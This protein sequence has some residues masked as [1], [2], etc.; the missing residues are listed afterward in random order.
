MNTTITLPISAYNALLGRCLRSSREYALLRNGVV[1]I[2]D[3]EQQR[4]GIVQILCEPEE[5]QLIFTLAA[6]FYPLAVSQI[7]KEAH[8]RDRENGEA[9]T[10]PR[11]EHLL[12]LYDDENRFLDTLTSFV[13]AGLLAGQGVVSIATEYHLEA[14]DARLRKHNIDV[15]HARRKDAYIPLQADHVLRQFV[16]DDW[17]DQAL[18]ESVIG[19]LL[20]RARGGGRG[21]RAF[22]EMV[23]L[24]WE[25][26]QRSAAL[27]L[28]E[29]WE[30]LRR[31][32]KLALF[33]AY[34]KDDFAC[35]G[36]D[37]V[38]EVC[39]KHSRIISCAAV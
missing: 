27:R 26:G 31:T 21:V 33:C 19:E 39:A 20:L 14:I 13:G 4:S 28:E 24:L 23:A 17:P 7:S 38:A 30:N 29:L 32:E 35:D 6:N 1:R 8:A 10:A 18:F 15:D 3:K 9:L 12:Q 11:A 16:I 36:V 2:G 37:Y 22:G 34:P 5:A 25:R